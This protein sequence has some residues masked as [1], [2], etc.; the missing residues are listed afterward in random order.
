MHP[1]LA[2]AVEV[3]EQ[4][5]WPY[6]A[7]DA[8]IGPTL[9]E[10][11]ATRDGE[12]VVDIARWMAQALAGLAFAHDGGAAHRDVQPFL[13]DVEPTTAR[14]ACSASSW[15]AVDDTMPPPGERAAVGQRA[16]E[17]GA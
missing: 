8:A 7:Y 13:L 9:A 4:E 2:H 5:R 6:I 1:N 3:G 11:E 10:R 14:C 15:H 16:A 12:A 17:Q